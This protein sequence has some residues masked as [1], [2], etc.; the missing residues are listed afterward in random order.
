MD[1][2]AVYNSKDH[3]IYRRIAYIRDPLSRYDSGSR[4]LLKFSVACLG[5][6]DN[7]KPHDPANEEEEDEKVMS[8][9]V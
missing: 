8:Q 9:S 6:G 3:E 5:P 1:L 7:Q 4:G 2:I